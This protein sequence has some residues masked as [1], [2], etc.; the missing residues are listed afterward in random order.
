MRL[1][2]G[3]KRT[4]VIEIIKKVFDENECKILENDSGL[5]FILEFKT[6]KSDRELKEILKEQ[7]I[8]INLCASIGK[9]VN[10]VFPKGLNL[11][12][13]QYATAIQNLKGMGAKE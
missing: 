10:K 2:Y 13:K 12:T 11:T 3:R 1:H 9:D 6:E 4:R 5:H 7:H 8:L